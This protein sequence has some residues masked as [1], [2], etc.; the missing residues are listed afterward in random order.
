MGETP[1][2]RTTTGT[3]RR[4]LGKD[5]CSITEVSSIETTWRSPSAEYQNSGPSLVRSMRVVVTGRKKITHASGSFEQMMLQMMT[6]A[7]FHGL[8]IEPKAGDDTSEICE[9]AVVFV[10]W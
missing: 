9:D 4:S 6:E 7:D 3:A 8:K 5:P 1:I 2:V 10:K